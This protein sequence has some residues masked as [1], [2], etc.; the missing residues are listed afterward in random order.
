MQRAV[1]LLVSVV[2]GAAIAVPIGGILAAE[3]ALRI[4]ERPSPDEQ[5]A[6]AMARITGADWEDVR[7]AAAD[8]IG[9]DAWVFT[10]PRPNGAAVILLHGVGDTRGGPWVQA[11]LLARN[12]YTV[13]LPDAR[14]HGVSGGD[15]IT[16]GLRESVDVHAW[17]EWLFRHR[18]VERL[19]GFGFSMGA[20]ILLQ[21]LP[22]EPRF[23]AVVAEAPFSSF[24]QIALDRIAQQGVPMAV[25]WPIVKT[26]FVWARVRYSADLRDASPAAAVRGTQTPVLLIHGTD[27]VNIPIAHSR[28]LAAENRGM[29]LW[30]VPGAHHMD[31]STRAPAA[32]EQRVVEWFQSHP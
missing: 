25:A 10:P 7:V 4:R 20:A 23:R 19:Y 18:R 1:R 12:G 27:D 13:L 14:G 17:A 11:N 9:L 5:L 29:V 28:R 21:S 31:V 32:Y 16:Y 3:N 22:R 6:R 15:I 24:E 30:E 26:G 8:G 2:V